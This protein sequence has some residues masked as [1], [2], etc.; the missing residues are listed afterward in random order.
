[1]ISNP[2]I[3]GPEP[4]TLEGREGIRYWINDH[5]PF[6]GN[7]QVDASL[8]TFP[9][10]LFQPPG[11]PPEETPI[12]IGLQGMCVPYTWNAFIIP[13]LMDMGIAT[14]L[15]ETPFAGERSLIRNQQADL[16]S[17]IIPLLDFDLSIKSGLLK[18]MMRG[19][20]RDLRTVLG[21]LESRHGLRDDR[22][23]F[24]GVSLGTLLSS[25][26]FIRDG[27]GLRLLGTIGHS[28]LRRF[29][30]SYQPYFSPLL[31]SLPG[32]LIGRL[33]SLLFGRAVS[34][35][36]EFLNLLDE[37]GTG[38]G[39]CISANPM[40]FAERVGP[41]RRVR[42]LV[43]DADP[44]VRVYDAIECANKFSDGDCYVV[45]GLAHGTSVE[46]PTFIEHVRYYLGTQL[47][48]W[49]H[50]GEQEPALQPA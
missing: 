32:R 31:L 11:R 12:V 13:T 33:G 6:T 22:R 35:N 18:T 36:L 37:L 29:A 4:I 30:L 41:D 16:V 50:G 3:S 24:F 21:L 7:A 26:A 19:V 25:F 2:T 9:V 23:A 27:L 45:P 8:S 43:G 49:R 48:D 42:F 34:A 10:A 15:M 28:D 38:T 1:M 14:V 17:E 5:Y 40:T 39:Q 20:A 47:G 46:G 44:V